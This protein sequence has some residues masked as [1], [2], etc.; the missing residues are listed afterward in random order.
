MPTRLLGTY[1]GSVTAEQLPYREYIQRVAMTA[2]L[3]DAIAAG[4]NK[5]VAAHAVFT[6]EITSAIVDSQ[7]AT[8]KKL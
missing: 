8:T 1:Y 6:K 7:V 3:E 4:A 2:D 5:Q